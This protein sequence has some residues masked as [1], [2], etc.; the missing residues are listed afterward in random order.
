M[1]R[2]LPAL[3]LA[4]CAPDAPVEPCMACALDDANNFAYTS[5]L[6]IGTLAVPEHAD[7]TIGWD[8][9]TRD[10]RGD[11]LDP[12]ADVEEA[13]L[14]A[15]RDLPADEIA[16][17]LAHDELDQADVGVY[18]TCA[19]S[20]ARCSLSAF[21]MFGNP[22]DIQQYFEEGYGT[23]LLALGERG[24]A[25]ADALVFLEPRADATAAEVAVTD[26]TSRLDVDVDLRSLAPVV[27]PAFDDGV[28]L[29]WS[30]LTRDGLGDPLDAATIDELWVGRFAETPAELEQDVFALERL[31]DLAWTLDVAG[32]DRAALRDLEGEAP[33]L[34]IDRQGTW[35]AALRCRTCTNPAPRVLTFLE[36]APQ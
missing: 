14:V 31:A 13:R 16:W 34:G 11:A 10:I 20:D 25:G 1:R 32:L 12:R 24:A 6:A 18:V 8:T 36:P 5:D 4:A 9:L 17:R 7:A 30:A 3:L 29:D 26:A 23:W 2:T 15:F 22:I 21:G 33:F 28:T 35:V 19:P 27:I